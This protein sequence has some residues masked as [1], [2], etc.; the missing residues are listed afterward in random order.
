MKEMMQIVVASRNPV[1]LA[2]VRTV[3]AALFGE[4]AVVKPADPPADRVAQPLSDEEA[5]GAARDRALHA[6]AGADFGVGVEGGVMRVGE[7][8]FGCN[9][10]VVAGPG[11]V[12]AACS[13]RYPLPPGLWE[14]LAGGRELSEL[15]EPG[16]GAREG[17]VA[18][19]SA[20]AITRRHLA[21]EALRLA[22]GQLLHPIDLR[23]APPP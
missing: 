4:A 9:W 3:A 21:E 10:A 5:I 1:K 20:G 18:L 12:A 2:A 7:M 11:G 19:V 23:R 15:I 14:E 13:A 16:I 6:T 17:A 22:F 8:L